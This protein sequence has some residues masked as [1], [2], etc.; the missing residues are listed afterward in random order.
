MAS[1]WLLVC[2][3]HGC[4]TFKVYALFKKNWEIINSQFWFLFSF[5]CEIPISAPKE[6]SCPL[7]Y[8]IKSKH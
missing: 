4:P 6:E 2:Y 3:L 7:G 5:E 8:L 1:L